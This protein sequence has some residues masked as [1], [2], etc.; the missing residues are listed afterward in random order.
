MLDPLSFFSMA[1][2]AGT[3]LLSNARMIYKRDFFHG[4]DRW[5]GRSNMQILLHLFWLAA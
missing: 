2:A 3:V 1:V 5:Q 4:G